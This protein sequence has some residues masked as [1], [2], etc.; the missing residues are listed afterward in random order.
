MAFSTRRGEHFVIH[1]LSYLIII[2]KSHIETQNWEEIE[3]ALRDVGLVNYKS[4]KRVGE[5]ILMSAF[6]RSITKIIVTRK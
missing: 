4:M 1:Y 5:T 3:E 2:N 6:F